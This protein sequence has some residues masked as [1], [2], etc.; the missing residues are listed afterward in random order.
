MATAL[1]RLCGLNPAIENSHV[2]PAFV[3]RAIRSDSPTGFF[4]NPNHPN[5]RLQDGDKL[6]LLCICCEQRFGEAERQFANGVFSEFHLNDQDQ[7]RYGPWLHY[8]MTSLA[9]RT[10]I[11]D[12]PGLIADAANPPSALD[13]L[14]SASEMMRNYLLG[15]HNLA[16]SL[17][18]HALA[19]TKGHS[20]DEKL[21]ACGPNTLIRRSAFG[22]CIL[23][24]VYEYS[25]II[26]N[27]AGFMCFF[28]VKGNPQDI[29]NGTRVFPL[30]G[31]IKQPQHVK[32]WLAYDMLN[33]LVES[34]EKQT[35]MSTAQQKKVLEAMRENPSARA[36]R[37]RKLDQQITVAE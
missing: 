27:L 30:K 17:R 34:A 1:C 28:I 29:W 13:R 36:W 26:H 9:W 4:R 23:D 12:L 22:Y 14:V 2:I 15:A 37:F 25:G 32:S 8:F 35:A 20:A 24:R 3:F 33:C 7:F 11:L 18:N 6:A 5:Q 10:L 21:A 16:G 31:E 19:W